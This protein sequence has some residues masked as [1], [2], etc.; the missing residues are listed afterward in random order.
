MARRILSCLIALAF[1]LALTGSLSAAEPPQ[2]PAPA[3]I[4]GLLPRAKSIA[5][6]GSHTCAVTT[7]GGIQC[8]GYNGS[9]QLGDESSY[10]RDHPAWVSGL[11]GGVAAA[12]AGN[13][14]TCVLMDA[15][16]AGG[17]RCWGANYWGQLG[18]GTTSSS[19]TP[20]AVSE[21]AN[22]AA[23]AAGGSHTCAI[24]P[25]GAIGCWGDNTYG[26]L[27][28]GTTNSRSTP[29]P[30]SGLTHGVAAAS[31]GYD[32]TCALMDAAH[33]G[34]VL[35]WGDN[36]RGQLGDG[37]TLNSSTPVAVSGLVGAALTA[38]LA[39]TCALS[40]EGGVWCWGS[41]GLGQLG[42]GSTTDSSAPVAVSGL[43]GGVAA[44]A[45]GYY[46]TC[47]VM[48][49]AHGGRVR[50]WGEGL[51]GQLGDGAR[52]DSKTPVAVS[53]LTGAVAIAAGLGH[54]CAVTNAGGVWCWGD[55]GYGQLGLPIDALTSSSTPVPVTGFQRGSVLFLPAIAVGSV[56]AG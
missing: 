18:D 48:D 2:P 51:W 19:W 38:G 12:S 6:G 53:G 4:D 25:G 1:V 21:V 35:C 34:L 33:G 8:W 5:V 56:S 37:T 7:G 41:N 54:T 45:A 40:N 39:H 14:H 49:A 16:H 15:A 26:Q 47:A 9:N 11:L 10:W 36:F 27:G 17:V 22:A 29:V 42:D 44:V 28:D 23:V 50:C 13:E 52:H 55:N 31:A 32:H 30:V 46:H 24:L 43:A 20:V 3:A